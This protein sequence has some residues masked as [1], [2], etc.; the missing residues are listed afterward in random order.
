MRKRFASFACALALAIGCIPTSLAFADANPATGNVIGSQNPTALKSVERDL[1]WAGDQ[2]NL[3]KAT[4]GS[5]IIAAGATLNIADCQVGSSIRT[6]SQTLTLT[7]T[8]VKNNITSATVGKDVTAQGVYLAGETIDFSGTS[9]ELSVAGK[10]VTINGT[11]MGDVWVNAQ[12]VNVGPDAKIAGT[13]HVEA[14]NLPTVP[15]T[16]QIGATDFTQSSSN[17]NSS[18]PNPVSLLLG[19]GIMSALFSIASSLIIALILM[20]LLRRPIDDS[21]V[22]VRQRT[23]PLL[24]T[25]FIGAFA[26]PIAVIL[27][28]CLGV[29]A[30]LGLTVLF[31]LLAITFIAVPFA[32]ASVARL[33]LPKMNRFASATI[34]GAVAGLAAA[35]PFIGVLLIFCA[36]AYLLGYVLQIAF[37]NIRGNNDN[38]D[39]SPSNTTSAIAPAP[40]TTQSAPGAPV[41]PATQPQPPAPSASATSDTHSAPPVPPTLR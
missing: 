22:M 24:L 9:T 25:G 5:D 10:T 32:G 34:G 21:A 7:D 11:V 27:L 28:L 39:G 29:T 23:A 14:Q 41:T 17:E 33:A 19:G 36:F 15:S 31:A 4:I 8:T 20:A 35:I 6:A 2:M 12:T 37:L 16:A 1:Y 30:P 40:V 3:N 18:G 38:P 26:A 13:L